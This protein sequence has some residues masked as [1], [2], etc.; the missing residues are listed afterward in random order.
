MEVSHIQIEDLCHTDRYLD[1]IC[2]LNV[3]GD[4]GSNGGWVKPLKMHVVLIAVVL[5]LEKNL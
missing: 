1:S 5:L 3:V 2:T 4:K